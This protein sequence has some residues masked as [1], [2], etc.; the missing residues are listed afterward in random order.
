M[1]YTYYTIVVSC[2][3]H[4]HFYRIVFTT[5][6]FLLQS[7]TWIP[8]YWCSRYHLPIY[9]DICLMPILVNLNGLLV[10]SVNSTNSYLYL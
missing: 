9:F 4:L 7:Q 8:L 1:I 10:Q 3:S 5:V 2:I 6:I